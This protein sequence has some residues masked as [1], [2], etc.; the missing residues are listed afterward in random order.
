MFR[1]KFP[2]T[3]FCLLLFVS[4]LFAQNNNNPPVT[5][6]KNGFVLSSPDG[7]F[8]LR[9]RGYVQADGRFFFDE[10]FQSIDTFLLKRVRPIFEGTLHKYFEFRIMP[11]FGNGQTTLQDAYLDAKFSSAFKVRF[12]KT[13]TP[14]GLERLQSATN[15]IFIE[16][17][18]ATALVPNRDV[19]I[20]VSGDLAGKKIQYTAGLMNGVVDLG[21]GDLETAGGGKDFVGRI[22]FS[23]VESFGI[24]IA[25]TAGDRDG[26]ATAPNLP[27][28]RSSG[29]SVFF[30]YR[31]GLTPESTTVA[32][33]DAVRFSPQF[34]Y[35][36]GPF[37]LLGE[38]VSS[39]QEV[40]R[41][42]DSVEIRND[43][44]NLTA[45]YVLTGE[46]AGFNGVSPEEPFDMDQRKRGAW[47]IAFRYSRLNI[48]DAAFPV[49]ADSTTSAAGA[50]NLAAGV[51]WYLNR[52]VKFSFNYDQTKFEKAPIKTEKLFQTRAQISW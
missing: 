50:D 41:G 42:M 17:S 44:W 9:L 16:R 4:P 34:T 45:H 22:F 43:A 3:L 29:Q 26:S 40:T 15:I 37:G 51:N 19:G 18:L 48:A 1:K 8:Q 31:T 28:Y 20:L 6:G 13:K 21:S 39:S 36:K 46:D 52:N 12:G 47:E 11:D 2:F 23:P 27:T 33:G 7:S 35:Y 14:F 38:Y 5:A 10:K 32:Q 30:R 25:I 24:G 49:F